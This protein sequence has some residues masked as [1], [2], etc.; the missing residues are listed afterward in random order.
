MPKAAVVAEITGESATRQ[1]GSL[2]HTKATQRSA[3]RPAGVLFTATGSLVW[4][5]G[6]LGSAACVAPWLSHGWMWLELVGRDRCV[7]R[8]RRRACAV[9]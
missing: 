6:L 7:A 3:L 4:I 2:S 1:R 8:V 5:L 9:A